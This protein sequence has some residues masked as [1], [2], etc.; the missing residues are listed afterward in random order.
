MPYKHT[1]A[2]YHSR[3]NARKLNT[4]ASHPGAALAFGLAFA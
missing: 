4:A 3:Q 1:P 2:A